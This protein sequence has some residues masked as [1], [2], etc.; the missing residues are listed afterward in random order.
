MTMIRRVMAT[1]ALVVVA[2][3]VA[4]GTAVADPATASRIPVW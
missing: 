4:A 2:V 3:G 1:T